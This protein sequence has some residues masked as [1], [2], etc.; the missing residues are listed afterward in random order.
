METLG[1][2]VKY[3]Q[4]QQQRHSNIVLVSLLLTLIIFSILFFG[5]SILD[6]EQV[7]VCQGAL[8]CVNDIT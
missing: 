2:G 5:V 4:S 8:V 6:F 1:K 3:A 7:N